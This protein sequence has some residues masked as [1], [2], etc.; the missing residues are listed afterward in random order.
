MRTRRGFTLIEL[1]VVIAII[2]ILAAILFPVFAR[3]RK[4]AHS[5][6]C[7]SKMRQIV[8]AGQMYAADSDQMGPSY[9]GGVGPLDS[10][11]AYTRHYVINP[12]TGAP[13]PFFCCTA[14][15]ANPYYG[16]LGYTIISD[17]CGVP[18]WGGFTYLPGSH[19][20]YKL[21]DVD[22]ND[23][24][25]SMEGRWLYESLKYTQ[26][27]GAMRWYVRNPACIH[28]RDGGTT[29]AEDSYHH[30]LVGADCQAHGSQNHVGFVDGSVR[31][32]TGSGW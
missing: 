8:L 6:A 21:E 29:W 28:V 27:Y 17:L 22:R 32:I 26:A 14:A 30:G 7:V 9:A 2:A 3:A 1:L 10:M 5:S 20:T 12:T 25:P 4:Q 15:P 31:S 19:V 16:Q 13:D 23:A 24:D 18:S 11:H